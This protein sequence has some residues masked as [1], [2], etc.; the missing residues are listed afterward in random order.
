MNMIERH[1]KILECLKED[2]RMS[3]TQIS[4]KTGIAI[5]TVYDHMVPIRA[6]YKF[7]ILEKEKK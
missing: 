5:S 3:L 7:T 2:S 1:M 4:K 6:Y